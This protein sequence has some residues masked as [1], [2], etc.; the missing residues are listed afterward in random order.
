ML[1][2]VVQ[3]IT[4]ATLLTIFAVPGN[5]QISV[6]LRPSTPSVQLGGVPPPPAVPIPGQGFGRTNLAAP[7]VAPSVRI[8]PLGF[9]SGYWPIYPSWDETENPRASVNNYFFIA[10]SQSPAVASLARP[11]IHVTKAKLRLSIPSGAEVY[12]SGK[13][14][15]SVSGNLILESPE[16]AT[17]EKHLFDLRVTWKEGGR[18]EERIRQIRVE[19]GDEKSLTYFGG[20]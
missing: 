20:K 10:P 6:G 13:K 5:A 16:L 17:G 11:M 18:T 19:A 1:R 8:N 4:I 12:V 7:S 14:L 2:T 3:P 9:Y 15:S